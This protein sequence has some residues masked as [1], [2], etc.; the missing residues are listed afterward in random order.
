MYGKVEKF[1]WVGSTYK[2]PIYFQSSN[3]QGLS[4]DC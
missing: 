3:N 1:S 4:G 2:E